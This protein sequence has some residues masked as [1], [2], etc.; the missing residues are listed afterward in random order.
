MKIEQ[1]QATSYETL[2]S[3]LARSEPGA[4][5]DLTV[6]NYVSQC[7]MN[8]RVNNDLEKKSNKNTQ[9]KDSPNE[10]S[11]KK[12]KKIEIIKTNND[13]CRK[14]KNYFN[15]SRPQ[16]RRIYLNAKKTIEE[17]LGYLKD[18][19]LCVANVDIVPVESMKEDLKMRIMSH[20]EAE[21]S[22][23]IYN[24]MYYKD[25][26]SISETCYADLRVN[27]L[28]FCYLFGSFEFI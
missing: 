27:I 23:N 2:C 13:K 25:K 8:A 6:S 11:E 3:I 10:P 15:L 12:H 16:K 7:I 22:P 21:N 17:S 28:L 24:L 18:M 14:R 19:G 4:Q 5:L 20:K 1:L 26:H 9:N